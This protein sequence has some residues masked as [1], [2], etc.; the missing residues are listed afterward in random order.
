ADRPLLDRS[1]RTAFL[2]ALLLPLALRRGVRSEV[3]GAR[4]R[5]FGLARRESTRPGT[6]VSTWTGAARPRAIPAGTR[7]G[8]TL[9]ARPCLADRKRPSFERLLVEPT[10]SFFRHRAVRVINERETARPAGFPINGKDDLGW[11]ADARQ[12]FPQ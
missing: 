8:R 10:N 3:P 2:P 7:S 6:A 12:V 9:F 11:Y 1:A 4:G 5:R